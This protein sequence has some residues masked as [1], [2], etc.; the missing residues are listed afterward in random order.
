MDSTTTDASGNYAAK[1]D[2]GTY[3]VLAAGDSGVV[4]QDSITVVKDST[5]HPPADTLKAPGS[6]RGIIRLQPGDD[7]RT[8]FILFMGTNVLNMPEDAIGN[9][10]VANMAEGTYRVRFLTTLDAYVP[11][12]TVLSASAGRTDS[13]PHDIVLQ[14][15]GIPVAGGFMFS[16]DTLKQI[17]TLTWN[18]PTTGRKISGYKFTGSEQLHQFCNS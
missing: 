1:L 17:V 4:Y 12:D 18:K 8:V 2:T 9:F 16:Y 13:V 7:A 3:N 15:T 6:I 10:S 5:V 14:Y 11:K